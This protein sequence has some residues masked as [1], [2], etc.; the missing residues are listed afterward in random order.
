M[1]KIKKKI[2]FLAL[3]GFGANNM[4]CLLKPAGIEN[5]RKDFWVGSGKSRIATENSEL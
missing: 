2:I 4:R 5:D 1:L 3:T